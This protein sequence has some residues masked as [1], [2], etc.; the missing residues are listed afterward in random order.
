MLRQQPAREREVHCIERGRD[1]AD[2][3][4]AFNRLLQTDIR[5]KAPTVIPGW[6]EMTAEEQLH[7]TEL[8]EA[9]CGIHK[10]VNLGVNFAKT[11]AN[12][13]V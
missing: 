6:N 13:G 7:R 10:G 12:H 1:R 8:L 9:T 5:V 2:A 4:R 11:L 3:A